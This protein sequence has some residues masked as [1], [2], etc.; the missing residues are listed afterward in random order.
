[1]KGNSLACIENKKEIKKKEIYQKIKSKIPCMTQIII[2]GYLPKG[3]P[4]LTI[5]QRDFP[6]SVCW[7]IRHNN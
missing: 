7:C 2:S 4:K 5:S 3:P 1:M 6:I